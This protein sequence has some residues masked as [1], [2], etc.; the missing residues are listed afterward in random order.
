MLK[1]GWKKKK[2][3][4]NEEFYKKNYLIFIKKIFK[5]EEFIQKWFN[6]YETRL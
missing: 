3:Y 5:N 4:M 1:R 6:F 2:M